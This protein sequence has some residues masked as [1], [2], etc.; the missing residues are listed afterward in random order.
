A[1]MGYLTD[2][3]AE[4]VDALSEAIDIHAA[5]GDVV[6]RGDALRRRAWLHSCAGRPAQ[7]RADVDASVALLEQ[8]EPGPE[9]ARAYASLT[10]LLMLASRF[11][12]TARVGQHALEL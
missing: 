11:E 5:S 7:A 6:R 1:A 8:A 10:G 3:R 9:L 2:M 4:A 12:E